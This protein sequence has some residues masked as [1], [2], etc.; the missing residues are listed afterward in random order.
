MAAAESGNVDRDQS[1]S[2]LT[3]A[4]RER[5][6]AEACVLLNDAVRGLLIP[7][8][9]HTLSEQWELRGGSASYIGAVQNTA[10]AAVVMAL[11]RLHEARSN[12]LVPWLFSET[13][14]KALGLLSLDEFLGPDGA[15][16]FRIVRHQASGHATARKATK[17]GPG[18]IIEAAVFAKAIRAIGLQDA[19]NF[20]ARVEREVIP[21]VESVRGEIMKR[22]PSAATFFTKTY[23]DAFARAYGGSLGEPNSPDV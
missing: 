9:I 6:A 3:E 4:E 1:L 17:D 12:F 19:S 7:R 2:S 15:K 11:W 21:G 10:I 20:L 16:A 8:H 22:Y 23:P 13:E 14:L 5:A 18:H